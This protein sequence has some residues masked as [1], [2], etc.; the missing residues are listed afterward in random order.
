M[1][2]TVTREYARGITLANDKVLVV[3]GRNAA[4]TALETAELYDSSSGTFSATGAMG[5][6]RGVGFSTTPLQNGKVLIAGGQYAGVVT[7]VRN[8]AEL[9]DPTTATFSAVTNNMSGARFHHGAALLPNRKVLIAGG[10]YLAWAFFL[11][12]FHVFNNNFFFNVLLLQM[13]NLH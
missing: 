11:F 12:Q 9:Y 5:A 6:T 3:G 8:N 10:R 2:V 13:R 7:D 4:G 1:V